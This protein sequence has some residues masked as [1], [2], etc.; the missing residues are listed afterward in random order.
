MCIRGYFD[1]KDAEIIFASPKINRQILDSLNR[2]FVDISELMQGLGLEFKFRVIANDDFLNSVLNPILTVGTDVADTA[3]LFMRS[4]QM[5]CMFDRKSN[6]FQN[7]K[8]L[9]KKQAY[10]EMNSSLVKNHNDEY[11][12]F[13]VGQIARFVM[14]KILASDKVDSE[15][16]SNLQN[17]RYSKLNL[18]LNFPA[19]VREDSEYERVRYY[20]DPIVINEI[21]YRLCSQW[22]EHEANNDRPYL[23]DWIK[24][25][26]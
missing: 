22:Y 12:E 2:C 21:S 23:I 11:A 26:K 1:S 14:M 8:T 10:R 7:S 25:Y 17:E 9:E 4:F 19:L 3:E 5:L 16:I 13:K 15:E 20:K 24:K 18:H 6:T